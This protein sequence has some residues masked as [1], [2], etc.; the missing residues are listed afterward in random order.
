MNCFDVLVTVKCLVA[1]RGD[2][3][4]VGT[5]LGNYY[6]AIGAVPDAAYIAGAVIKRSKFKRFNND[7]L[8]R[9]YLSFSFGFA[10]ALYNFFGFGVFKR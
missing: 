8:F 7:W 5:S 10:L 1:D 4:A 9:F 3:V 6:A 2:D